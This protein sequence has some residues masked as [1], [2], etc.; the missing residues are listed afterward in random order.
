M[1]TETAQMSY[2]SALF[3]FVGKFGVPWIPYLQQPF[4][5]ENL[6]PGPVP[7]D[8]VLRRLFDWQAEYREIYVDTPTGLKRIPGK[9][10][11][12]HGKDET[13]FNITSDSYMIHQYDHWL[14]HN[15]GYVLAT[16][17]LCIGSAGLLRYGGGAFISIEAP[18]HVTTKLG[19]EIKPYLLAITSHDGKYATTYKRV[20]SLLVCGNLLSPNLVWTNRKQAHNPGIYKRKHT[21]FSLESIQSVQMALDLLV[22]TGN[23]MAILID[24]LASTKVSDSQW[25]Q[26]VE[27]SVPIAPKLRAQAV[28]RL[29]N[30][31]SLLRE[32]W[33]SDPRCSTWRGT[34]FGAFQVLNTYRNHVAG[35]DSNR[36][37]RV[38]QEAISDKSLAKDNDIFEKM[39]QVL[40]V[41]VIGRK[42]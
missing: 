29:E 4:P 18:E 13:V 41:Q 1:S 35:P 14:V 19:V 36:F 12:V 10:A 11:I 37:E 21:K 5:K 34:A 15:L 3:G 22:T 9:R 8:D 28:Q 16:D 31:R 42:K 33:F 23:E 32:M 17:E 38:L 6:Y 40:N 39:R 26:I 30:K 27:A 24:E 25:E 20:T 7:G 2:N